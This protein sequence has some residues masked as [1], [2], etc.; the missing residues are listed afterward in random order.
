[1]KCLRLTFICI[2]WVLGLQLH[3]QELPVITY[4]FQT[5][6]WKNNST[7]TPVADLCMDEAGYLYIA[8]KEGVL[9][10]DGNR[11]RNIAHNPGDSTSLISNDVNA[12]ISAGNNK[13]AIITNS[14]LA[15]LDTKTNILDQSNA[16]NLSANGFNGIKYVELDNKNQLWLAN[17]KNIGIY[18]TDTKD[19]RPFKLLDGKLKNSEYI[20]DIY[21]DKNEIYFLT[22]YHLYVYSLLN[23]TL[24]LVKLPLENEEMVSFTITPTKILIL[25]TGGYLYQFNKK[26]FELIQ[27]NFLSDFISPYGSYPIVEVSEDEFWI[28]S[29]LN[30]LNFI[31]RGNTVNQLQLS[32][33]SDNIYAKTI[34]I[35]TTGD[36]YFGCS[37]NVKYVPAKLIQSTTIPFT[38]RQKAMERR[39]PKNIVVKDSTIFS[40]D[41][42]WLFYEHHLPTDNI[43]ANNNLPELINK[44]YMPAVYIHPINDTA[45]LTG[46]ANNDL[47][48]S[49]LN[50]TSL[51]NNKLSYFYYYNTKKQQYALADFKT[52]FFNS[53]K[54]KYQYDA[55][56]A[57]DSS[58][59]F[60]KN[61]HIEWH[62]FTNKT[63]KTFNFS[64]DTSR[65]SQLFYA[66]Y[67]DNEGNFWTASVHDASNPKKVKTGC[68]V[69]Y[70]YSNGKTTVYPANSGISFASS[71]VLDMTCDAKGNVYLLNKFGVC[72]LNSGSGKTSLYYSNELLPENTYVSMEIDAKNR[73]WLGTLTNGIVVYDIPTNKYILLKGQPTLLSD[74]MLMQ[75]STKDE[76]NNL[77]FW[78]VTGINIFNANN[79]QLN[80]PQ[81]KAI[82]SDILMRGKSIIG[83]KLIDD[84]ASYVFPHNNNDIDFAFS[85]LSFNESSKNTFSYM[86]E[87]VDDKWIYAD[88]RNFAS[89]HNLS[90]GKYT[91]LVKGKNN[92]GIWSEHPAKVLIQITPAFWQTTW[93]KLL[94]TLLVAGIIYWI[95]KLRLERALA[96][97]K[98]RSRISRDLHDDL[99]STLSSISILSGQV[100]NK[101]DKKPEEIAPLLD[102]INESSVRM[103]DSLQDLVWAVKPEND[104]MQELLARMEQFA[105]G[106]FESKNIDYSFTGAENIAST[107]INP[108]F[109]R[110]VYLI[111]KEAV[112]NIAKYSACKNA[113]IVFSE[114]NKVFS[115]SITDDGIGFNPDTVKKGNGLNNMRK[116]AEQIGGKL[117]FISEPN[118]KTGIIVEC[119]ITS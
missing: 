102:K 74:D 93:F 25:N 44:L 75:A 37:N 3:A 10:W 17:E 107:K 1:M 21:A 5:I 52:S 114:K 12:I 33:I 106:L 68:L 23:N 46:F 73:L 39:M 92:Y 111:F 97:E 57:N 81:P 40:I 42:N 108:E 27:S 117:E 11:M 6:E 87:G 50:K 64:V 71:I 45:Y 53:S 99:G 109:I 78:D 115:M 80:L 55:F 28:T 76:N 26:S 91:F 54:G 84:L 34:L 98:I 24:H 113:T 63:T 4:P 82:V 49:N 51:I 22:S 100:K 15:I 48:Q 110:N 36:I 79:I 88:T 38:R 89:Y 67:I 118:K 16:I 61:N 62:H 29:S 30:K 86:L 18:K 65:Y 119:K 14:G 43:T 9:I 105:S 31:I 32:G 69:K 70:H 8:T 116:R 112:N 2:I 47:P 60:V 85:L 7:I 90:P 58:I 35:S 96:V 83:N 95:Y 19:F 13:I 20:I 72:Q 56:N 41:R 104:T 77:Y 66:V 94:C 103:N 59:Y 101:L